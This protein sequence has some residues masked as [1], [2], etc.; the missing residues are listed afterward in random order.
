MKHDKKIIDLFDSPKV[1]R[2]YTELC[3]EGSHKSI[4]IGGV[5]V[6]ASDLAHHYGAKPQVADKYKEQTD[7]DMEQ[8]NVGGDTSD[9][10]DGSSKE[11]E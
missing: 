6:K 2:L 5:K 11:Q 8:P 7:A 3:V 10:G 1:K 4:T 9:V